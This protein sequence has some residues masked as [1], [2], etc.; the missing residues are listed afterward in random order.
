MSLQKVDVAAVDT[1]S[2]LDDNTFLCLTDIGTTYGT[3]IQF[4]LQLY[5]NACGLQ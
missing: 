2:V 5:Y 4:T 3:T 1:D